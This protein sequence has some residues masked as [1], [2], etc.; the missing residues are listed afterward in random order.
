VLLLSVITR[1]G[2]DT[3]FEEAVTKDI[4]ALKIRNEA[5]R[6]PPSN[7]KRGL[8]AKLGSGLRVADYIGNYGVKRSTA[9]SD[10]D[11]DATYPPMPGLVSDSDSDSSD[12]SEQKSE[13]MR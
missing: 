3:D 12:H 10:S 11:S 4:S 7:P 1:S 5:T 9:A 6:L 2:N 8:N 13:E